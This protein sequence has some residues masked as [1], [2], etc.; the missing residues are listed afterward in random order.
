M[1]SGADIDLVILVRVQ[2]GG[3]RRE[4]SSVKDGRVRIKTTAIAAAGKANEDVVRQLADAFDVPKSRISLQ[5]G[6]TARNKTFRIEKPNRLPEWLE[7]I[8]ITMC[9]RRK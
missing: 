1:K 6:A 7:Q 2:P 5:T 8:N 9:G 3:S 4:I